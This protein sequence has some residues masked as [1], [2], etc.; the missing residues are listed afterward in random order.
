M[1]KVNKIFIALVILLFSSTTCLAGDYIILDGNANRILSNEVSKQLGVPIGVANVGRFNDGEISI[2]IEKSVRDKDVYI[3]QS[4]A[5]SDSGS[6][7]DNLME[8]YLLIRT[9]KRSSSGKITAIIPYF[10]YARQDRKNESRVPI[11]ASDVAMLLEN[12]GVDRVVALDLHAGQIQGFFHNV[13]VDNVYGSVFMAPKF[14]E[15]KLHKPVIVSPDAGGVARAKKFRDT[16]KMYGVEADLAIIIKQ[17]A[18]A[19]VIESA[20]LIGDVKNRDVIIVDDICDTG[21]TLV[22]A[23]EELKKFGANKVYASI[24]HPVF[25]KDAIEKIEKSE[26]E[27]IY[28]SDSIN[29]VPGKYKKITQVSVANL[30]AMVIDHL[31]HGESLSELFIPK[32]H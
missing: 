30:I 14:A 25:S 24:T 2:K 26:F 1:R 9:L 18:G 16:L 21:G 15:L 22:K 12:S 8:L 5:K 23:A 17:R 3:I 29:L 7:N 28:V 20:N 13:P 4:I 31:D 27:Q 19:G 32:K 6:V 11:S 10:G